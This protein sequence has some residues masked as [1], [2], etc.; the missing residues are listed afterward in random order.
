MY[1]S[2]PKT[3]SSSAQ[4]SLQGASLSATGFHV[5]SAGGAGLLKGAAAA[6]SKSLWRHLRLHAVPAIT[7]ISGLGEEE[8]S[9]GERRQAHAREAAPAAT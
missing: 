1:E 8:A 2:E 5:R 7:H 4:L 9:A 6:Q 3:L